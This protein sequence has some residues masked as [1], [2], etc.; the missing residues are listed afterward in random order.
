M[1]P[2]RQVWGIPEQFSAFV[3]ELGV[4]LLEEPA[5]EVHATRKKHKKHHSVALKQICSII[6]FLVGVCFMIYMLDTY[7][8]VQSSAAT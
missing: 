4:S 2:L 1:R 6:T 8:R 5:H 7:R 3:R